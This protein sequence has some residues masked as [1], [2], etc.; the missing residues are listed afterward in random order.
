VTFMIRA[1][2]VFKSDTSRILAIPAL[3][4]HIYPRRLLG[5]DL[6]SLCGGFGTY[7]S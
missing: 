4:A 2:R 1:L 7:E 5:Q 3:S 6:L